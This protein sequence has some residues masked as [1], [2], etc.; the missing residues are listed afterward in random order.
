MSNRRKR[1]NRLP[2]EAVSLD[3]TG[4]SHEGRGI[5]HIEGKVAFVGGAL[6]GETV[7]ANYVRNRS[8]FSELRTTEVVTASP[9]RVSPPCA[10]AS[11]C[12]GC[13]L[14]HWHG[15]KQLDFKQRVLVEQLQNATSLRAED[16]SLLPQIKAQPTHY[17][18]KAR[19]AVRKVVK[20][21]GV[22]VGFREKYSS[23]ITDMHDCQVLV[24]EAAA[25]IQ[26]LR[27][28]LATLNA[29]SEIPQIEVAAGERNSESSN[30]LKIALVVRHL[31]ALTPEDQSALVEFGNT[32]EV[33][34]Y[35]QPGGLDSV[36]KLDQSDEPE[37]LHYYLPDFDLK[38]AFHPLDFTQVNG[39]IN[40]LIV[41]RAVS[42]LE[43]DQADTV[44][45][46]FCG[47]GNFSLP[48]AR[49]SSKVVGIEGSEAMVA[50]GEENAKL[51]NI[52]NAEFF[53]ADLSTAIDSKSWYQQSYSKILLDPP[54][55]GAI[56]IIPQ[57][58]KL[59]ASKIVYISCNPATL[60]RDAAELIRQGYKLKSAG[61]M[62]MFPH[63]THVES[64]AEFV[65]SE[66]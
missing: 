37:R 9:D 25:L 36:H 11:L 6:P 5:S 64:M 13:S 60:A 55:S 33:D 41:S 31:V 1:R 23:F 42:M 63:T 34:I 20:K 66:K 7:S 49:H 62:D 61:V 47:L 8:Q 12:G 3:I 10:Y 54:R 19:L 17:R 29:S 16:Y 18:R 26:P 32:H 35:L 40:R 53:A 43:L 46:L 21:G 50:R 28:F 65:L 30:A 56:E 27:E 44:L 51:N 45:D 15:D 59:G 24:R 48:I 14:Q 58:A 39:E 38:L 52:R 2:S 4:L 22:L 57:I